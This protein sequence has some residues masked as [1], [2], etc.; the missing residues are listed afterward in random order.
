MTQ[1][2]K[3]PMMTRAEAIAEITSRVGEPYELKEQL[4]HGQ[5][6]KVFVNAASTLKALYEDNLSDE[7]LYVYQDERYTFNEMYQQAS[8]LGAALIND[9]QVQKGDRVAISMR[10]YPEWAMAFTAVT[11]IGAVAVAM[12][13]LWNSEEMEYGLK[14]CGAKI[15]FADQERLDRL[16]G[17]SDDFSIE[18]IGVRPT[19]PLPDGTKLI[20]DILQDDSASMPDVDFGPDDDATIL[21]TSGSTGHPKGAVSSHRNIISALW[22]WE[23]DYQCAALINNLEPVELGYQA[24]TLMGVPLFHVAGSHAIL[25]QSY[26]SQRKIVAMYKWDVN[27]GARLIEQEKISSFIAP[28]A[29]T[30]DMVEAA[31]HGKH[32]LS[33]LLSVGGGGA[34]RA[35]DQVKN[36]D[37]VFENAVPGTGWGMTETNAIGTGI[38]G[39]DYLN[40]PRSSGRCSAVLELRVVDENDNPLPAG[41]R[42]DLLIRGTSVIRG[43]WDR[44]EAN[45]SSFKDGW[46]RTGDIAY[47]DEEGFLF[48]VDR[49]KDLVIRG[50]E[51]VGC[52]EVEAALV[53]HPNIL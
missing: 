17:C 20:D 31:R 36:I 14:H 35:P 8:K 41:E 40:R 45:E 4:V 27:E 18:M 37:E 19:K 52:G 9:Y 5:P 25:L 50:G 1:A 6:C 7:T 23:L 47:I 39:E 11:S 22:S 33:T 3:Q 43:Y 44:P 10:N 21:Y 46:F 32:D 28:A 24:A 15:I 30:G 12:N 2:E 42:G 49:S 26:R 53:I 51:N 29:M 48:I 16:A 38:G 13:A 34:P